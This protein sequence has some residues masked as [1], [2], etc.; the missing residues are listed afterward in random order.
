MES[1]RLPK[2]TR[3]TGFTLIEVLIV[4][5]II[6]ILSAIALPS[7]S[8]NVIK[9]R[10]TDVQQVIEGH[11]QSLERY[12]TTN[13]RYVTAASGTTCGANAPADTTHYTFV[14]TCTDNTFTITATPAVGSGQAGDGA[15]SLQS[16]GTKTGTWA[17]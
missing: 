15:Q 7:Y 1:C 16:D 5:A 2:H 6:G 9:T 10:R 4:V 11:A 8:R 3:S 13:G 17:K 14:V 12:N